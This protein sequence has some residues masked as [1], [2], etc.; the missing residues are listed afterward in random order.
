MRFAGGAD[1]CA[2]GFGTRANFE[3]VVLSGEHLQGARELL[4]IWPA[5][6]A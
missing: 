4:A 2:V 1:D 3:L 6:W 5:S